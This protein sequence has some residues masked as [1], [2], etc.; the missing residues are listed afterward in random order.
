MTNSGDPAGKMQAF[1]TRFL[2]RARADRIEIVAAAQAE[3]RGR[4]RGLAHGLAGNAGLFGFA[5]IGE[6]ARRLEDRLIDG[7][8]EDELQAETRN[9]LDRLAALPNS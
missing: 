2:A 3:D 1:R 6:A 4:L 9:L 7:A 8:G 5:E